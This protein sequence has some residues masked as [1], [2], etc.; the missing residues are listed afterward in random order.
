MA[1]TCPRERLSIVDSNIYL[2]GGGRYFCP[3][4]R[5]DESLW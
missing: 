1:A 3:E 2:V 5:V 4:R